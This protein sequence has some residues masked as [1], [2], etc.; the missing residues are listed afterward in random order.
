MAVDIVII[1]VLGAA[2]FAEARRGFLFAVL[3]VVRVALAIGAGLLGYAVFG[4]S[5]GSFAGGVAAFLVMAIGTVLGASY[6]LKRTGL[7]PEWGKTMVS[8]IGAGVIGFGLGLAICVVLIPVIGRAEGLRRHVRE[9]RLAVPFLDYL[10]RLHSI[11][12]R[13]NINL[14]QINRRMKI[15]DES[16]ERSGMFAERIN[17]T[18]LDGSTC[19]ECGAQVEFK[20]YFR[21]GLTVSPKFVCP[22]CD[23]TSDGCQT[24]EGFHIMYDLCPA[25]YTITGSVIDCGVWPNDRPVRAA[26]TCP[27][28]GTA[29]VPLD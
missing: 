18:R 16:V 1:V 5:L 21:R 15:E 3:D 28:C 27:V 25:V 11:A 26:G 10:P 9:S 19:I 20:G 2:I 14:P 29:G 8:R 7:D 6:L 23:R 4:V 22:E 24:Y 13:L 12:D 17:Y